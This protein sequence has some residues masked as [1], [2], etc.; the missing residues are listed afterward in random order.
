MFTKTLIL[1]HIYSLP[2]GT[3]FSTR[4]LLNY[5]LRN[6]IDRTMHFLV[7]AGEIMRLARGVFMK[8][9]EEVPSAEEIAATKARA[10][11]KEIYIPGRDAARKM[12]LRERTNT[13]E[14]LV[15]VI[16][17]PLHVIH[18]SSRPHLLPRN[19]GKRH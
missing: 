13:A 12:K 7:K 1:A 18:L 14:R 5:G 17:G 16:N 4:D 11:G 15:F 8:P 9:A 10:F 2:D 6:T 3:P 19:D